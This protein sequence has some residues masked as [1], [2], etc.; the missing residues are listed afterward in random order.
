MKA[1]AFIRQPSFAKYIMADLAMAFRGIGWNVQWLDLEHR[2][3][4]TLPSGPEGIQVL[5]EELQRDTA[6][7]DPGLILSYGLEYLCDGAKVFGPAFTQ[8]LHAL[9]QR[10]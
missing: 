8:P 3:R 10:P 2:G 7:F 6:T 4:E 9:L 1:L 5:I